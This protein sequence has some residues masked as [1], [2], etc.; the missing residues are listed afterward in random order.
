M[1][2][3]LLPMMAS[4]LLAVSLA[5]APSFAADKKPLKNEAGQIKPFAAGETVPVANGGTGATTASAARTALGVAIG[6]N[7]EA[8]DADLAAIA[9]VTSAADKVPY[10]TGSG[11]AAVTDLTSTG[12]S[13]IDDTSTSA[14][15]TTLGLGTFATQDYATPPAIG[16]TTPAAGAFTTLSATGNLTTNVTGS[17]QC[18]HVNSS[19]VVSGTASD[20]GAGGGGSLTDGDKGDIT[21]SASGAT[22]T[23]DDD[24][25]TLA[26]HSGL[27]VAPQGR[28][29]LTSNTPVMNA[30]A[31]AQG[32]VYYAPHVGSLLPIYSG[33]IWN[34]KSF[35][36][37]SLTL[38]ATDNTSGSLYDIYAFNN[39]GTITLGTGPAWT[40]STA[41]G[42]GAGT[43][44][45]ELKDGIW[46]NKVSITLRA[47]GSSLGSVAANRAT[48][49]GTAYMTA[50]GQTG[51]AF[52]PSAASGGSNNIL[53]LY[54]AYN[55]VRIDAMC[56]DSAAD[57]NYA[58]TTWR[59]ANN[60][61]SNRVSWV[62]GLQLSRVLAINT[63]TILNPASTVGVGY[64]G[65]DLD[66]TSA[67][68]EI[69][70]GAGFTAT[71]AQVVAT[72]TANNAFAPQLG[73]HY[74]QRMEK[75]STGTATFGGSGLNSLTLSL[76]M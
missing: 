38:N 48:Y 49:L 42:T 53:G 60:S 47:G 28:L 37:L 59:S 63:V 3:F 21:V 69:A 17:T 50:N 16:G 14:M 13:L 57:Y 70:G 72:G 10:F 54:N 40:S 74:V 33:S 68:P 76:E 43:T 34:L 4:L 23:I 30:D 58:S 45:L 62:D 55:R 12:R 35:A 8:Y 67:T 56:R 15:R 44:E 39:S 27:I 11:T 65:V 61:A 46:T 9:G 20:C 29:T 71:S 52:K 19:G 24:T 31:T 66:S 18:L 6:T 5:G 26:K 75:I 7:V 25:V 2:R 51:M 41:R 64:I 32:T 22:W 73:L 1:K 36:Q